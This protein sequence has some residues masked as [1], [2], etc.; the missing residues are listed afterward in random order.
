MGTIFG[1]HN[2]N[3]AQMAVG[4]DQPGGQAVGVL[5]LDGPPGDKAIDEVLKHPHIDN[6]QVVELP[7]AG[8]MPIWL[9]G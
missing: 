5:N 8:Q 1:T 7:P 6:A 9:Q 3:I 2:V 4:R